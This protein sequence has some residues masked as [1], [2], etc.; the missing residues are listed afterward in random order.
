MQNMELVT[1]ESVPDRRYLIELKTWLEGARNTLVQAIQIAENELQRIPQIESGFSSTQ[2][3]AWVVED[4]TAIR[5]GIEESLGILRDQDREWIKRMNSVEDLEKISAAWEASGQVSYWYCLSE[6]TTSLEGAREI[7]IQAIQRVENELQQIRRIESALYETQA[8]SPVTENLTKI[9]AGIEECLEILHDLNVE[10]ISRIAWI[11]IPAKIT[12]PWEVSSESRGFEQ[13]LEILPDVPSKDLISDPGAAPLPY[14]ERKSTHKKNSRTAAPSKTFLERHPLTFPFLALATLLI[15]GSLVYLLSNQSNRI[16]D[17]HKNISTLKNQL[18]TSYSANKQLALQNNDLNTS[19]ASMQ[20]QTNDLKDRNNALELALQS[21]TSS[22][23]QSKHD[24]AL[25]HSNNLKIISNV[26]SQLLKLA[27][28]QT[29]LDGLRYLSKLSRGRL[30]STLV[31]SP[32]WL[33]SGQSYQI[34]DRKLTILIPQSVS[35]NPD[36]DVVVQLS[37]S[38]QIF[39]RHPL[40]KTLLPRLGI[41]ENFRFEHRWYSLV[42]LGNRTNNDGTKAY[43]IAVLKK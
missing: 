18:S 4:L 42:L 32:V 41:P 13:L 31:L 7:F 37:S 29:K 14:E 33:P 16:A 25:M 21:A 10:W 34:L 5:A 26:K 43:L 6:L 24:S 3:P 9:R 2:P 15:I 27:S 19:M 11:E 40:N 39:T 23:A 12:A 36:S 35:Q 30:N 22:L 20:V 38:Q 8:L 1:V 28:T 17:L